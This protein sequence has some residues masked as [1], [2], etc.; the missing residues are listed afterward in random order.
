MP[1]PFIYITLHYKSPNS[2]SNSYSN[3]GIV[4]QGVPQGSILGPLL[5][6]LPINDLSTTINSR[7]KPILFIDHT[8]IIIYHPNSNYFQNSINVFASLKKWFKDNELT[9]NFDKTNFMYFTTSNK[10]SFNFNIGYDNKTTDE[11]LTIKFLG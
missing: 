2:N 4:K 10:T 8:S 3:W 7:S 1:T 9:L 11:V 5:F 6:L